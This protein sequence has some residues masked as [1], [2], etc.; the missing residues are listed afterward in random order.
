MGK[1]K[2]LSKRSVHGISK[3]I[4]VAIVVIAVVVV[5]AAYMSL[6]V[7]EAPLQGLLQLPHLPQMQAHH[8]R[9][10]QPKI[11]LLQPVMNSTRPALQV[12]AQYL[13]HYFMLQKTLGRLT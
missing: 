4:I 12:M 3:L 9:L 10:P 5:G 6:L 1:R 2:I 8:Q 11:L 7:E 13:T